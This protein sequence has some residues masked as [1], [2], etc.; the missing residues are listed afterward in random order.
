[1]GAYAV[2]RQ[3]NGSDFS[4]EPKG[5]KYHDNQGKE[6]SRPDP[7]PSVRSILQRGQGPIQFFN[8]PP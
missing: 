2:C 3:K 6:C 4:N 8:V 5:K 7:L 1:M